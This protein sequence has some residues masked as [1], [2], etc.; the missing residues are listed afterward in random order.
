M[1]DGP[2]LISF[3]VGCNEMTDHGEKTWKPML[4]IV[5]GYVLLNVLYF[6]ACH[7]LEPNASNPFYVR[8]GGGWQFSTFTM[9]AVIAVLL[10]VLKASGWLRCTIWQLLVGLGLIGVLAFLNYWATGIMGVM[11]A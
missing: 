6:P 2:P 3:P 7:L 5:G 10:I 8:V 11:Y 9:P 4:T 1:I